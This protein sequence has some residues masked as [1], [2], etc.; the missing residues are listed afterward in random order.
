A[1]LASETRLA[2]SITATVTPR[3]LFI[4]PP[5]LHCIPTFP[6]WTG[7]IPVSGPGYRPRDLEN[8]DLPPSG[9]GR[10]GLDA[11]HGGPG[12]LRAASGLTTAP[13]GHTP[14]AARLPAAF[15]YPLRASA[16]GGVWRPQ[17][18]DPVEEA[19]EQLAGHGNLGHLEDEVAAVGDHLRADLHHLLA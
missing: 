1:A 12:R 11:R 3:I 19:A 6:R 17:P 14:G 5:S 9:W 15:R 10:E 2:T 18:C 7:P 16:W 13:R 8:K 4:R